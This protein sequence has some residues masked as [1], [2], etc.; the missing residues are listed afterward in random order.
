MSVQSLFKDSL[1]FFQLFKPKLPS[2]VHLNKDFLSVAQSSLVSTKNYVISSLKFVINSTF[3]HCT[4]CTLLVK[5]G[6]FSSADISILFPSI[7]QPNSVRTTV[8]NWFSDRKRSDPQLNN[9]E[10]FI[11]LSD[12]CQKWYNTET[13]KQ[14]IWNNYNWI[15]FWCCVVSRCDV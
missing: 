8:C 6:L 7:N 4:F 13:L 15:V 3:A 5:G 14:E 2:S 9:G 11:W 10:I 1:F 12:R